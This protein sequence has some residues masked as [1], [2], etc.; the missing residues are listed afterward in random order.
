MKLIEYIRNVFSNEQISSVN[1]KWLDSEVSLTK[2]DDIDKFIKDCEIESKKFKKAGP[3]RIKDWELGW[4]GEGVT[5]EFRE[6]PNIPYY[7]KNNTHVRIGNNVYKDNSKLTELKLLRMLQDIAFTYI[8]NEDIESI[9]EYGCGTGQNITYLKSYID[10]EFYGADWAQSAISKLSENGILPTSNCFL[11]DYFDEL[12]FKGPL[13]KFCAFT[14]ASLEQTGERYQ[15]FI[16]YLID[17]KNCKMGIHIEP[18]RDLITPNN[19]LN[20]NSIK[21]A[22]MRGYLNGFYEFMQSRKIDIILAKDFGVG[23][24]YIS[25]YQVLIWKKI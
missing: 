25:G 1:Q 18:I 15:N 22:E 4:S 10:K 21:Y 14:N 12:T 6:F 11:V 16:E 19:I 20:I 9:I 24:K 3:E 2:I 13:K 5:N 23:S 7:F 8:N 17:N